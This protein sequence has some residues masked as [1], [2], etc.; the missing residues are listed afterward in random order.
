LEDANPELDRKVEHKS[1][2]NPRG[3]LED[4]NPELDRKVEHKS[5]EE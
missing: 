4:A 3:D 1:S 2:E 5:S